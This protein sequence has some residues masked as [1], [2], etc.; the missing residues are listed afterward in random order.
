MSLFDI[1]LGP[2][3]LRYEV[4]KFFEQPKLR[5]M[6]NSDVKLGNIRSQ[7]RL[8]RRERKTF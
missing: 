1:D 6:P 4:R 8:D 7:R 5:A 2:V 3:N